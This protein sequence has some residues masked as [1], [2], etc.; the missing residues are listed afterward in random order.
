MKKYLNWATISYALVCNIPVSFCLC[1]A[2]NQINNNGVID[3]AS[4]GFNYAIS[5]P[6]AILISLFVPLVYIGKWFTSLFGLRH[7]TFTHNLHYRVLAI[8]IASVIF[9][10]ILN[11]VLAIANGLANNSWVGIRTWIFNW[12]RSLPSML[13][14][15][16]FSSLFF[17]I[18]AYKVAHKIDPNF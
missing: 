4:V 7:D 16:F 3:W 10:L 1:V 6:V 2:A 8:F 15:G 12:L 13:I 18:P 14:V 9:F 5:L 11:P 17:D